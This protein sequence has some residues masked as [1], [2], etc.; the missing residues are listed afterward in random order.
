MKLVTH[1]GKFHQDDVTA[2]V[3]LK[4]IYPDATLVRTRN[5]E[6]IRSGCVV[7]DVGRVFDPALN[8]FDHHQRG[9]NE[10]F[11]QDCII[12]LSSAGLI[13]KYFTKEFIKTYNF[14]VDSPIFGFIANRIYQD[15]FLGIDG[16]DNGYD[17]GDR[18]KVRR[19][20][21]LVDS[22]NLSIDEEDVQYKRFVECM[23]VVR[24]DLDN[25]INYKLFGWLPK[26]EAA[27]EV[28]RKSSGNILITDEHISR[29]MVLEL[30]KKHGK[31]IMFVVV[32]RP[33]DIRAYAIPVSKSSFES[34]IPFKESWRGLTGSELRRVS[35][36]KSAVFV[37]ATGFLGCCEVL[38]DTLE[39]CYKAIE[40]AK[41]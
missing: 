40:G 20:C 23:E 5:E 35:G 26:Y 24:I 18:Y 33:K 2:A 36:I 9:F 11:S 31:N 15:F 8:R 38:E 7:F 17:I 30:E 4:K 25:F 6:E 16:V 14:D 10:T 39:M 37:H 32:N 41:A 29:G 13:F 28:I 1:N 34:K 3:I 12:K 27:D 22:F 21:D 19:V